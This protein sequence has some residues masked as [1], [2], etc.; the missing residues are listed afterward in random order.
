MVKSSSV[1]HFLENI[2]PDLYQMTRNSYV[3]STADG[4]RQLR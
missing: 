2:N 4:I 1:E 3:N